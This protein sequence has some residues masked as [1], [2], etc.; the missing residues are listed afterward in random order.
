MVQFDPYLSIGDV[1]YEFDE[2]GYWK[3]DVIGHA[4]P[5]FFGGY[6]NTFTWKNLS[7][8]ALFTFSYGNDLMYQKDVS[9]MAMNSL[10]NR[11]TRVLN[12][13][14]KTTQPLT[15]RGMYWEIPIC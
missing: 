4:T 1:R 3:E 2:T 10:A 8:L 15:G 5:E 13:I 11:G 14:V 9:D 7:L 6:T 12:H